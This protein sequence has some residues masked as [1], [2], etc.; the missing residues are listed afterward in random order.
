MCFLDRGGCESERSAI[1][2]SVDY[3]LLTTHYMNK[4]I[5]GIAVAIVLVG[6]VWW[7]ITRTEVPLDTEDN[8][9]SV[10]DIHTGILPYTSGVK[11]TVLRGPICPVMQY[12]PNPQCDDRP[13]HTTV[14]LLR[15]NKKFA[16][17]QTN[18][19][20]EYVFMAP[21]GEYVL[22]AVSGE[23]F[24]RCEDEVVIIEPDVVTTVAISCDTGIR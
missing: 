19:T 6:G 15:D 10:E 1:L 18:E 2:R 22:S 14:H 4:T 23:P 21:P 13:Y 5:I 16:S 7:E 8:D 24:P 17:I 9:T 3:L 12:P 20:G 11:G